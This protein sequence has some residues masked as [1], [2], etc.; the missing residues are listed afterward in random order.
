[1]KWLSPKTGKL[2]LTLLM[3]G[4]AV[5]FVRSE[6]PELARAIYLLPDTSFLTGL[7]AASVT[8]LYLILSSYMYVGSF[9]AA[10]G[11]LSFS[12]AAKLWIRRNFVSVFLP[13][14]GVS[15]MAFYNRP[16]RDALTREQI[17]IGSFVY[18]LAGYGSLLLVALPVLA[19]GL[20]LPGLSVGGPVLVVVALVLLVALGVWS[21]RKAG[22]VRRLLEK[23]APSLVR[24]LDALS[25]QSIRPRYIWATLLASVGVEL[26]GI[27]HVA[28]AIHALGGDTGFFLA[29]NTYIAATLLYAF[30]P[31]LR[32]LGAVEV[33]MTFVLIRYGHMKEAPAVAATLYYR[34]FEFWLPLVVGLF[35][36]FWQKGNLF[37]RMLPV[38]LTLVMGVVNLVSA[39]TPALTHRLRLLHELLSPEWTQLS[40][41]AVIVFGIFLILLSVGLLRGYRLAWL[42]T[43][44]LVF[45]SILT[46]LTKAI[47]YEEALFGG[48]VLIILLFTQSQYRISS[49]PARRLVQLSGNNTLKDTTA[50][51]RLR[52]QQLTTQ[53]GRSPLDYFKYYPDKQV[54][55][56]GDAYFSYRISGTSV[57]VLETPVCP[58]RASLPALL[59]QFEDECRKRG[60]QVL[61]YRVDQDDLP[62][63]KPRHYLHIG[64]EALVD[65]TTFTLEGKDRKT[66]RNA[67]NRI[68]GSGYTAHTYPAPQ[69]DALLQQLKAVSIEWLTAENLAETAFSQGVFVPDALKQQTIITIENREG[70]VVAFANLIPD[71]APGE[72]TYDLIRKTSDA[73]NG[74]V[75]VL[76]VAIIRHLQSEGLHTLN[77]GLAPLSGISDAHSLAEQVMKVAYERAFSHF[78]GLRAF[79]EKYATEWRDK[80]LIYEEDL[81]LL[82]AATAIRKV[83]K[84]RD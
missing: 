28:L 1:M 72:G 63:F 73:P 69:R 26:C 42:C 50:E 19:F 9:A 68:E 76:L 38:F 6:G 64:Q 37:L 59:R 66:L 23:Y 15:A 74:V 44:T 16:L 14:G 71:Y 32:G 5:W 35:S 24:D 67:L 57:I 48:G 65:L 53:F 61:Y 25:G 7:L 54:L 70:K 30:S 55:F 8:A 83:S 36:F 52:A 22:V 78:K 80:Y 47:D 39:F 46:H 58:P 13:A 33:A 2:V 45:L 62:A 17:Y 4:V 12:K 51:D 41:D 11:K 84:W 29:L 81:D 75:D 10:G 27:A 79:K 60:F 34:I 56:F 49:P 21:Y 43:A 31:A 77:M 40:N 82:Q 3:L 18:V 20:P